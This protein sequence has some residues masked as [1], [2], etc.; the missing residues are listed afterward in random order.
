M[1]APAAALSAALTAAFADRPPARLG[2]AISGGGNSTALAVLLAY[3]AAGRG[4]A[5]HAVTVDHG[6]RPEAMVEAEAVARFC[7][8]LGIAHDTLRWQGKDAS[9]NLQDQARRARYGLMAEWARGRGIGAIALG[10]TLED[11]AETFLLR[12]ARGSG[13]DGLAAMSARR[14]RGGILWLRPLLAVPR[15]ALRDELTARGLGWIEDPSNEDPRFDRVRMRQA[16]AGLAPLGLT[17]QRLAQTAEHMQA[18]RA[19]LEGA[20]LAAARRLA[21]VQA[22]DVLLDHAGLLAETPELRDRL[23]AHAL[24]FVGSAEYRPRHAALHGLLGG[25]AGGQ[26][27]T[28]HGCL[29]TRENGRVRIAREVQAVRG[30]CAPAPGP[31]DRRWQVSGPD[32]KGLEIRALDEAG[33]AACPGWRDTGLPRG[34]LLA[35]PAVWRGDVLIAAPLAQK[36]GEWR[37]EIAGGEETFFSL[38]LSH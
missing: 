23:L 37:A 34:S 29:L 8:G 2:I 33:L 30:L 11:Q 38:I 25:L 6:L 28:L 10:H 4:V 26:G 20:T 16:M 18:A 19:A 32:L 7:A 36:G 35:S 17:A 13:V 31:W 27:G 9:G 24:C 5:L 12:L 21:R 3:W 14:E 1:T 15:A 22:G